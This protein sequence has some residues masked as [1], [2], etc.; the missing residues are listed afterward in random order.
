MKISLWNV[1]CDTPVA[2]YTECQQVE[3]LTNKTRITRKDGT[4][5][6][7][8]LKVIVEGAS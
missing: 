5:T 7:T 1:G 8:D 3:F 4:V 2:I 6:L